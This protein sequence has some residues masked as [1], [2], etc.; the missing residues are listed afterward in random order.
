MDRFSVAI[1]HLAALTLLVSSAYA[2]PR[3]TGGV[4]G[5]VTT[6]VL[7]DVPVYLP[8]V[9]IVLRCAEPATNRRRTLADETG[10]FSL[11]DLPP[12]RCLITA[13]VKGF[14]SETK[15]VEIL[16]NSVTEI[17]FQLKLMTAEER[18]TASDK[19][20]PGQYPLHSFMHL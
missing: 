9:E 8:G 2:A 17:L 16:S 4:H 19:D 11:Q 14:H 12:Q 10:R 7:D 18:V 6:V 15:P 20:R 1:C 13:S 5:V 3:G